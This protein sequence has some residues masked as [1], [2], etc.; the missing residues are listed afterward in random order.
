MQEFAIIFKKSG[1]QIYEK[2]KRIFAAYFF[3]ICYF[4]Y[5]YYGTYFLRSCL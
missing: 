5:S 1:G 2:D 4:F 3:P